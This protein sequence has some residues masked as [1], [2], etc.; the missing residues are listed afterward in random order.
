MG[1]FGVIFGSV[2]GAIR[3]HFGADL[4]QTLDRCSCLFVLASLAVP[5]A[6]LLLLLIVLLLLLF[7]G[8]P[9][10]V[11]LLAVR[12]LCC[13]SLVLWLFSCSLVMCCC[14]M[15]L[16]HADGARQDTSRHVTFGS[17]SDG[18]TRD[19]SLPYMVGGWVGGWVILLMGGCP[20]FSS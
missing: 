17:R 5:F 4:K 10:L 7:V 13:C 15:S 14:A 16:Q 18:R 12:V 19:L 11:V 6:F 3:N 2:F 8:L 20:I 1:V 9:V